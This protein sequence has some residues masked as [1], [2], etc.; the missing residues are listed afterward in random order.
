M[1]TNETIE[2]IN[3]ELEKAQLKDINIKITTKI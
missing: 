3:R 2:E 1:T